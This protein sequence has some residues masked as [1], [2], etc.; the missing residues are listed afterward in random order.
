MDN[1]MFD[2]IQY[3]GTYC[4]M[5]CKVLMDGYCFQIMGVRAYGQF[6]V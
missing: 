6:P 1:Q 2:L 4:K 3:S 5:G